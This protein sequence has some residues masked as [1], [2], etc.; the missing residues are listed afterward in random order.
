M[1]SKQYLQSLIDS[2]S[3]SDR[4][5]GAPELKL[6][7]RLITLDKQSEHYGEVSMKIGDLHIKQVFTERGL[8]SHMF[9]SGYFSS[10]V[11]EMRKSI[12]N[13]YNSSSQNFIR[14]SVGSLVGKQLDYALGVAMNTGQA[15][16]LVGGVVMVG[17][18]VCD[19]RVSIGT[20]CRD[21]YMTVTVTALGGR[22][23]ATYRVVLTSAEAVSIDYIDTDADVA[24]T[25]CYIHTQLGDTVLIPLE[26]YNHV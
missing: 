13:A 22:P 18:T 20:I 19:Y 1:N 26:V 6:L 21:S 10:V 5:I 2:L 8:E 17:D 24:T 3:V 9:P 12:L 7:Q 14:V 16:K 25:R 11:E 4:K 23:K 15:V